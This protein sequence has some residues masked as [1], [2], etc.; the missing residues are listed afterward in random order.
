MLHTEWSL[1][2]FTTIAQLATGIM[3]AVLPFVFAKNSNGFTQD[4]TGY[5]QGHHFYAKL[6]HTA[7]YFAAGLMMVALALSFL[8]LN[9]PFHSV[10]A[11]SNLESSWLSREI[12]LVSLFLFSL[13]LVNLILYFKNP[14]VKYYRAFI[15]G[16][17]IIGVIMVYSMSRL[18]MIPTVPPWNS[19]STVVG[20]YSTALL[21]GSAFV[22][23][24]A[25]HRFRQGADRHGT[26][27]HGADHQG[28]NHYGT[29][30]HGT[31]T[32]THINP[33]GKARVLRVFAVMALLAVAFILVNGLFIHPDVSEVNVA[34]KPEPVHQSLTWARWGTILLGA[35]SV[36]YITWKKDRLK[37]MR[38]AFYLPFA[39]FLV[40]ELIARAVFYASYYRIGV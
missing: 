30:H 13:V 4:D 26:D 5:S 36:F 16:A 6:N 22:L 10:Y 38:F 21:T 37:H 24:L 18:Y 32:N 9:K 34:F 19:L 7:L 31:K 35:I 11:L 28:T 33:G 39:F 2:F 20:F 40:S 8:H 23:G 29:N 14:D 1:V 25:L 12:L 27:H 17:A 15:L 3:I